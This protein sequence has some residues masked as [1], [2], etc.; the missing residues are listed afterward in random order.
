[1]IKYIALQPQN[2]ELEISKTPSVDKTLL[3]LLVRLS[4]WDWANCCCRSF[5]VISLRPQSCTI[6]RLLDD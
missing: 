3:R 1:M 5:G 6:L 4:R 2:D